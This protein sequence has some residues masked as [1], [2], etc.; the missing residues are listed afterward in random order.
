MELTIFDELQTTLSA[1]GAD[2]AIARLCESLRERKDLDKLFYALLLKKRHELGVSPIPTDPA[3]TLPESAHAPYEEAI[4]QAG[5]LVGRL[6]LDVGDIPHAWAYYRMIGEPQ[7]VREALE[8]HQIKEDEDCQPVIEVAFHHAVHVEKGFD[9]ILEKYG[10]CSTITTVSSHQF[11]KPEHREYSIKGLVRAL[12]EQ[13]RQRLTE[14]IVGR[15]GKEPETQSVQ[16]MIAGRDWL[17]ADEIYHVDISHLSAIVQMSIELQPSPELD[18]ARE[19]CVYGQKL[20]PRLHNPGYPPFDDQYVDYGI[21]LDALAGVNVEKAIAHFKAKVEN[22]DPQTAGTLPAEVLVNF[23]V[24]LKRPAEALQIVRRYLVGVGESQP[25]CPS[26]VDLCK[27][28]NDYQTLAE[29]A[30]EQN[31]PVHFMAGLLVARANGKVSN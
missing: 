2:A 10:I 21:Y 15:E 19:L 20:C 23:L 22:N 28:T 8:K 6:Y 4:R 27:E 11:S 17:F 29:V 3:Q 16:A 31:D 9:W 26:V 14:E 25:A 30:R 18:L 5:R 24:R 7:P 1:Q 13:I 12:Y